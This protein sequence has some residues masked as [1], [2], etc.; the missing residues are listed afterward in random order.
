MSHNKNQ[1]AICERYRCQYCRKP[2][3]MEW[4]KQNHEKHCREQRKNQ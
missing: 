3:M 1:K 4:A 2:Y